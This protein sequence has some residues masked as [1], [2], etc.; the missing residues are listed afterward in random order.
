MDVSIETGGLQGSELEIAQDS[1]ENKN[2]QSFKSS[3]PGNSSQANRR[4]KSPTG[5]ESKGK[6]LKVGEYGDDNKARAFFKC[7]CMVC[8]VQV[9]KGHLFEVKKKI[10]TS[11]L[12]DTPIQFPQL[13]EWMFASSDKIKGAQILFPD[14]VFFEDG[15]PSF[16]AKV[17]KEG[18]MIKIT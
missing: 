7:E 1:E 11:L 5:K 17:D 13:I 9:T 3:T 10:N 15:K 6:K 4:K 8:K 16:I 14:T 12:N 18:C 2:N